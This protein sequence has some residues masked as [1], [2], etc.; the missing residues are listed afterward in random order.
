[1]IKGAMVSQVGT[2]FTPYLYGLRLRCLGN[3]RWVFRACLQNGGRDQGRLNGPHPWPGVS[4]NRGGPETHP[5]TLLVCLHLH[6]VDV[7]G[8]ETQPHLYV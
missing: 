6:A 1:M 4:A 5:P 7:R 8:R 3:P 2:V